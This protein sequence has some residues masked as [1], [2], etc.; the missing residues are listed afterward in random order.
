VGEQKRIIRCYLHRWPSA[1]AM[2]RLREKI[3]AR[4]GRNRV[5]GKDIREV[6]A[7]LNPLLRG[8]PGQLLPHRECRRQVPSGRPIRRVAAETPADQEARQESPRRAG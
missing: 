8:S 4:T 6:I 2:K 1:R 7:D 5:G 3:R